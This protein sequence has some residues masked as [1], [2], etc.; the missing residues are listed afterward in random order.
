MA[1]DKFITMDVSNH[2]TILQLKNLYI[3]NLE[4]EGKYSADMKAKKL[5]FEL[6]DKELEDDLYVYCY[7]IKD[8]MKIKVTKYV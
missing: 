5:K 4:M 7:D 6:D 3:I 1:P 2:M 8:E